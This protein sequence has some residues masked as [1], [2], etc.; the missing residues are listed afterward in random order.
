MPVAGEGTPLRRPASI[1]RVVADRG[2]VS[3]EYALLL[4][5]IA[6]A[7]LAAIAAFGGAV[8]GLFERGNTEIPWDG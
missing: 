5:F 1:A 2:A 3:T 6:I 8:L 4:I 7:V